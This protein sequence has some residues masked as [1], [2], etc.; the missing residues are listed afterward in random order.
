MIFDTLTL[1]NFRQYY[2]GEKEQ[3]V[4]F[5]KSKENNITVIHGENG[6][7]KTALLNSFLW[8]LYG[9]VNLPGPERIVNERAIAEAE[10]GKDI[11]IKVQL[12][13]EH[14][15]K[16]YAIWRRHVVRKRSENDFTG[17][18]VDEEFHLEYIDITGKTK[19]PGNPQDIIKQIMPPSLSNLF[20][21]HG[22]DIDR[23]SKTESSREIQ[24]SIRNI[25]GL[26]I[27]ERS[28]THLDSVAR[29]FE[30]EMEKYGSEE[31]KEFIQNKKEKEVK[32]KGLKND[33][34]NLD[35]N[36]DALKEER[37]EVN[38]KLKK[39]ESAKERQEKREKL[40]HERDE[41]QE[42]INKKNNE[43]KT[44]CGKKAYYA[45]ANEPFTKTMEILKEK[46]QKGEIPSS[47]KKQ[48][49]DD[50]LNVHLCICARP[51]KEGT[52]PYR[53]VTQWREK[54]GPEGLDEAVTVISGSI[55]EF[56]EKRDEFLKQLK[57]LL[58][59]KEELSENKINL[60]EQISEIGSE[61]EKDTEEIQELENK[62]RVIDGELEDT[63]INI[64]IKK[65]DNKKVVTEINNI[66]KDIEKA[67][68]KEARG[69]IAQER[70]IVCKKVKKYIEG[71]FQDFAKR[72]RD[73]TQT[74]V[75]DLYSEFIHK[76]YWA[77]I[78]DDYELKIF[79]KVKDQEIPVGMSTGE[80]QIASLSFIGG[81]VDIAREQSEKKKDAVYFKGGIY[82]I[83]MDA[84]FG[85]LDKDYREVIGEG[86]PKLAEQVIVL[87][88]STQWKGEVEKTMKKK[89]D[90][91]YHLEYYDPQ[92]I[93]DVEYEHTMIREVE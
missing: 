28:I 39:L 17:E 41:T 57:K 31:L 8:V 72:V 32:L 14:D 24:D 65:S 46:R 47:I 3:K 92:K 44:L 91:E 63:K 42:L 71:L 77:K 51:L 61:F 38:E 13:F 16:R 54:A 73:K 43:I 55:K 2:G 56:S 26:T 35:K 89:A 27:L 23:M 87:V 81:L 60:E 36:L 80:R 18:R 90:K 62:R 82:P 48:F 69:A 58:K 76:P 22:E 70:F 67:K 5:S 53:A 4:V 6:A 84:P 93:P 83:I 79:K 20:F 29:R 88:T 64:G 86:M 40:E 12:K 75:G 37:W 10:V 45:F 49:V 74:K 66:E 50:L 21:F 78:T 34:N 15:E 52:D 1:T 19:V 85:Y 30:E 59:E 11:E 33:L 7:G 68:A 9:E 25:M